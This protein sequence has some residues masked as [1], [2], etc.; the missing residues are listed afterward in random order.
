MLRKYILSIIA[1]IIFTFSRVYSHNDLES[2]TLIFTHYIDYNY[3]QSLLVVVGSPVCSQCLRDLF[4][5]IEDST[6]NNEN[7]Y[8]IM[9]IIVYTDKTYG[10]RSLIKKAIKKLSKK[11]EKSIYVKSDN[12]FINRFTTLGDYRYPFIIVWDN[13]ENKLKQVI[14]YQELFDSNG[15]KK[16]N[17]LIRLKKN[18]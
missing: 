2:D 4:N 14:E 15:I 1:L 9:S 8:Y 18:E 11:I 7:T 17:A 3:Q 13:K 10:N 6:F 16:N 5:I 12:V